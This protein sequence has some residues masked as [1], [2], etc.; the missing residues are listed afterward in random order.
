MEGQSRI[1]KLVSTESKRSED[2]SGEWHNQSV[3]NDQTTQLANPYLPPLIRE[4]L[5]MTPL[6]EPHG[7]GSV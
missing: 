6:T 7:M 3:T 1:K 4:W 5:T 2:G